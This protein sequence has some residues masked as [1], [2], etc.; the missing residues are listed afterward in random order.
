MSLDFFIGLTLGFTAAI[1]AMDPKE[2]DCEKRQNKTVSNIDGYVHADPFHG[3]RY[4]LYR[5]EIRYQL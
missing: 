1:F 2:T 5:S 4:K 3:R